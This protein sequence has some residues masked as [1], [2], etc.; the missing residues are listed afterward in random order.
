V[1]YVTHDQDEALVMSDR[2][3]IYNRGCIEQIG[4]G[5]DLYERPASTF[6][7]GFVGESN[8]FT[9][10]LTMNAGRWGLVTPQGMLMLP[11]CAEQH[12]TTGTAKA[13]VVRPEHVQLR[14]VDNSTVGGCELMTNITGTVRQVVY[15]GASRKYLVDVSGP[16]V[17]TARIAA[18]ACPEDIVPGTQVAVSWPADKSHLVDAVSPSPAS[19]E[20]KP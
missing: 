6:V 11:T 9:G 16:A 18:G 4:S 3:A 13:I 12:L 2:I 19:E 8:I 15:L 7:A 10:S 5:E 17:V 20:G 1:I 14:A